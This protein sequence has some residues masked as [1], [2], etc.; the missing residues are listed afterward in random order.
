MR[1]WIPSLKQ[2]FYKLKNSKP[3]QLKMSTLPRDRVTPFLKP[4]SSC[5][6]DYCSPFLVK[7]VKKKEMKWVLLFICM[8]T[9]AV[10]LEVSGDFKSSSCMIALSNFMNLRGIPRKLRTD[11]ATYFRCSK[12]RLAEIITKEDM[13]A[14]DK[15]G[16]EWLFN[17]PE[18]PLMGECGKD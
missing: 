17:T 15:H 11:N 2:Q 4:F 1:F 5:G 18:S 16:L 7:N 10:H 8:S 6:M 14:T 3:L 13:R 9:R 12:K